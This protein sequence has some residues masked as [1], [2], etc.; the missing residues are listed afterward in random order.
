MSS[1]WVA[2][3]YLDDDEITAKSKDA[4]YQHVEWVLDHLLVNHPFGGCHEQFGS[5]HVDDGHVDEHSQR[6]C[7]LPT[8]G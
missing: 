3:E 4:S 8:E 5:Y 6:L 7:L 2:V 1:E